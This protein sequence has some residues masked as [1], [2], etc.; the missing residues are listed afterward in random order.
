MPDNELQQLFARMA[1]PGTLTGLVLVT[2]AVLAGLAAGHFAHRSFTRSSLAAGDQWQASVTEGAV[3]V[4]P[5]FATMI[6]LLVG[7]GVMSLTPFAPTLIDVSLQLAAA[8]LAV[9]LFVYLLRRTLGPRSWVA[10]WE[11]RLTV[12]LWLLFSFTLLGWFEFIESS[13]DAMDLI[14][15]KTKFTLWSLMKG[16][17]VVTVFLLA[18]SLVSRTVEAA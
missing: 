12:A 18:A 8:L 15:G 1:S 11:G 10:R 5:I 3:V 17:V 14:P 9:R 2:I 16:V 6:L 13:L 4:M 7:R